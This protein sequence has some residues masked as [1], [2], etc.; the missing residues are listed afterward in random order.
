MALPAHPPAYYRYMTNRREAG[1]TLIELMMVVAIIAILAA[2]VVPRYNDSLRSATEGYTRGTLGTLRRAL[3]IYYGDMEGVYP[4]DLSAL[5]QS[6]RYLRRMTPA[7]L[8]GSHAD[9]SAVL[10]AAAPDDAG[11]WVYNNVP[12][13]LNYGTVRVNCTHTDIKNAVWTSY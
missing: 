12:G 11:G 9:S 4:D 7:R 10:N 1:F 2:I 5:T 13:S 6:A 8:P 3:S